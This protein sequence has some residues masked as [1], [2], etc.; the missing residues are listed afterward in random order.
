M[1]GVRRHTLRARISVE[2]VS[3]GIYNLGEMLD[4]ILLNVPELLTQKSK[5]GIYL[6]SVPGWKEGCLN[7]WVELYVF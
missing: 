1:L 3:T 7:L 6:K 2:D 4:C 5:I